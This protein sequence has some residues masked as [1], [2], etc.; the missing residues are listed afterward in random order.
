MG[1][2]VIVFLIPIES[3]GIPSEFRKQ[4]NKYDV[5]SKYWDKKDEMRLRTSSSRNGWYQDVLERICKSLNIGG[6]EFITAEAAC[7]QPQGIKV[8]VQQM[9]FVLDKI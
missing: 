4:Q 6:L 1:R 8:A 3:A 9:D 5:I 2:Q 7:L